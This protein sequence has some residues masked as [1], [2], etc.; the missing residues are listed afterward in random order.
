M[1]DTAPARDEAG[2]FTLST[3]G[4]VGR[5]LANAEAGFTTKK[6]DPP[7]DAKS[8]SDDLAGVKEAARD[9]ADRRRAGPSE[10]DMDAIKAEVDERP[11]K[12]ARSA[13]QAAKE[14]SA[15]RSNVS[16][17]VDGSNFM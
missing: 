17:F 2:K 15:M 10:L 3:E 14:L 6:D 1:S 13:E 11:L 7:A 12:E 9:L 16:K 8:Y 5:E 4:L